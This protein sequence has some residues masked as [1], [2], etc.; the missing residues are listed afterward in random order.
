MEVIRTYYSPEE[1]DAVVSYLKAYGV[2]AKIQDRNMLSVLPLDS[3]ALGGYRLS[4]PTHQINES[5]LLLAEV[6][7]APNGSKGEG[8]AQQYFGDEYQE[9]QRQTPGGIGKIARF[10]VTIAIIFVVMVYLWTILFPDTSALIWTQ[11]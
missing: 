1:A 5:L 6:K 10:L 2:E 3:V 4:V 8:P 7:Q 11:W 9:A